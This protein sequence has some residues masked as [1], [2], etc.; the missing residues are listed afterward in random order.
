MSTT[1]HCRHPKI[2]TCVDYEIQKES[3]LHQIL[4][5]RGAGDPDY[6]AM[7]A[8]FAV[9]GKISQQINRDPLP[10]VAYDHNK[11]KRFHISVINAAHFSSLT[12]LPNPPTPITP[13]VYLQ[14]G[15]PWFTLYD[16]HIPKANNTSSITRL[17]NVQSI[18]QIDER[19]ASTGE[20]KPQTECGYCCY[21]MAT[22]QCSPCGHNFCDSCSDTKACPLCRRLITS[23]SRIA[24]AMRLPGKE[25]E[26]GVEATIPLDKRIVMLRG[27]AKSGIVRSFR[28]KE[29][30]I[31]PLS[32]EL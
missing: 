17:A 11:V 12:G 7:E 30:R 5:L 31:S 13:Q 18:A 28:L 14:H 6:S 2:L 4:R 8:G 26:D 1:K 15:L 25:D 24:A 20:G 21:E 9:G 23:R 19:R 3:T 16:E 22:Q 10:V 32:G 27:G 29:H